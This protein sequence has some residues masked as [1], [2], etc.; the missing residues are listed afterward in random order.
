MS[1]RARVPLVRRTCR[2]QMRED[3]GSGAGD[4]GE[5]VCLSVTSKAITAE[6][7]RTQRKA[8][9]LTQRTLRKTGEHRECGR[10]PSDGLK[11]R[12]RSQDDDARR[13]VR[14]PENTE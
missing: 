11:Q 6:T 7:Q 4:F 5:V 12:R 10:D 3:E 13:I 8:K 9:D 2:G 1:L 14:K